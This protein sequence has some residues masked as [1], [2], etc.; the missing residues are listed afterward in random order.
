VGLGG[1]GT[2]IG[3]SAGVVASGLAKKAC[4]PISFNRFMRAG[5]PFMV[6]TVGIGSIVLMIDVMLRI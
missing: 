6:S 4:Y 5:F 3:S 2:L 1:N